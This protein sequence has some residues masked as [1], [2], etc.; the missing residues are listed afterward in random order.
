MLDTVY[1]FD[2]KLISEIRLV[3]HEKKC[4]AIDISKLVAIYS[5]QKCSNLK[6]SDI[7]FN[8]NDF[9]KPFLENYSDLHFNISHSNNLIICA[10]SKKNI[11]VDIEYIKHIPLNSFVNK[12]FTLSEWEY[13]HNSENKHNSFFELWTLK[14]SYVKYI[15]SGLRKCF[16][17]FEIVKNKGKYSIVDNGV[18]CNKLNLSSSNF[19]FEYR[20]SL[21]TESEITRINIKMVD[22]EKLNN[23]LTDY[24]LYKNG[25]NH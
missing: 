8:T 24:L 15:G 11:G 22:L 20:I 21:C 7:Q 17:K 9:G 13:I 5:I 1:V 23:T 14:E 3:S 16:S 4:D 6:I 10:V 25:K 2:K 12:F 19:N 18:L